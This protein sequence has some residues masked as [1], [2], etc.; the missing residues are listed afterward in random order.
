VKKEVVVIDE[1]V[2]EEEEE[3]IEDDVG[4]DDAV[5]AVENEVYDE[6]PNKVYCYC[7]LPYDP[8]RFY[9]AVSFCILLITDT[10]Y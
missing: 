1:V 2:D 10:L 6:D 4:D 3:I 7:Q 9:I 5:G 8:D